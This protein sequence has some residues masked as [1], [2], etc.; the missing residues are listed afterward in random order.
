MSYKNFKD[1]K[2]YSLWYRKTHREELRAKGRIY[3]KLNYEKY[4]KKHAKA[5]RRWRK[6]NKEHCKEYEHQYRLK[7][8]D[9][10]KIRIIK[11][12]YH[13]SQKEAEQLFKRVHG[14]CDICNKK[15][16]RIDNRKNKKN[17]IIY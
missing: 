15:E 17:F 4:Y 14:R 7:Y 3:A 9:E 13:I 1:Q 16:T 5:N 11:G 2:E 10:I 12:K 8:A 6:N